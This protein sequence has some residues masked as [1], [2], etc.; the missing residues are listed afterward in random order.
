LIKAVFFRHNRFQHQVTF[1]GFF[2]FP[3]VLK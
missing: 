2:S 3:V 1:G